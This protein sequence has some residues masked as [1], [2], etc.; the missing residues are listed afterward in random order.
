[1]INNFL[2]VHRRKPQVFAG[3][4]CPVWA[5]CLRGLAFVSNA[6]GGRPGFPIEAGDEVFAGAQAYQFL[7]EII[8][9]LH[10]PII[11]ETEVFGQF[12]AFAPG[13]LERDPGR[14]ALVQRL[15]SDAKMLRSRHLSHLGTQ[16]YG[17]WLRKN[18]AVSRIHVL[19]AGQ[20][21]RE[22]F[23][24]LSKQ[25]SVLVHARQPH[26][27]NFTSYDALPAQVAALDQRAFDCGALVVAA[28]MSA[29]QIQEWLAGRQPQQIF[30]LRDNS[31]QDPI[32]IHQLPGGVDGELQSPPV[33]LH[34]IFGDIQ[35]TRVRLLPVVEKIKVEILALA[36]ELATHEKLRPQGWDDLCA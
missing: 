34:A 6:G 18:L 28:P 21:V 15:L 8:C 14:A 1:M 36:A 13:W 35:R 20:L 9:G 29:A 17:S 25:G 2:L 33:S 11:G 22:I 7:L 19:G 31:A 32:Q 30:D 12:K 4:Q 27:V 26:K 3:L 5:T 24:Y 23:P 16:S 10:S